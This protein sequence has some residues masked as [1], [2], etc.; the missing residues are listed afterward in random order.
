MMSTPLRLVASLACTYLTLGAPQAQQPQQCQN[1]GRP[2][3]SAKVDLVMLS[4][5]VLDSD[6]LPVEE[7]LRDDFVVVEDGVEQELALFLSPEE[8]DGMRRVIE[9]DCEQV[10]PNEW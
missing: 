2:I 6:D 5:S 1:E 9:E 7:L 10:D 4:V 8:A 3:F